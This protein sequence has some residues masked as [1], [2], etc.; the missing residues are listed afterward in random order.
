MMQERG[1]TRFS[2][3]ASEQF[4]LCRGAP[5]LLART[6]A[7]PNSSYADEGNLAHHILEIGLR[8]KCVNATQAIALSDYDGLMEAYLPDEHKMRDFKASVNDALDY[9]WE[10]IDT[11]D[12]LYGDVQMF[13]EVRVNPPI[14]SAPGEAAG[15]CDIAIYSANARLLYVIDYKHGQGV[16]KAIVGNT[17]V[18]QYAAGFLYDDASPVNADMV[19]RVVMV[20][21]QPRAFHPDGDIR[22]YEASP[23]ELSDYLIELDMV[24]EECLDPAAPLTAG[25][26]QCRFCD[27]ATTCP[28]REK[29]AL[30]AVS[31]TFASIKDIKAPNMPAPADLDVNR[32]GY[33]YQH[34]DMLTKWLNDIENHIYQLQMK[35]VN[36]PGTKLVK[37]YASRVW[38]GQEPQRALDL[39]ALIGCQPVDLY[40]VSFETITH[41]EKMVVEAFKSRVG[42]GQKKKAAED[43]KQ[44][45]AYFTTK[46]SSDKLT[47]VAEDDERPAANRVLNSFHQISGLLPPP[48]TT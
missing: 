10:T 23:L 46:E 48:T 7:R 43:A 25:E 22:E 3:S 6:P 15:Y 33:I 34:K 26:E 44:Y 14:T 17:Q 37:P 47:L 31:S 38:H 21:V 1:H 39:A 42:R 45:F 24:I 35:G 11:L 27:A 41:L 18:K 2:P 16:A 4:F 12:G 5:N 13:I 9:I 40:R 28:A 32:L 29:M 20:I 8:N 19:D 30:A 36:V